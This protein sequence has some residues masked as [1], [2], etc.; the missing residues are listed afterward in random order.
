MCI[1]MYMSSNSKDKYKDGNTSLHHYAYSGNN[2]LLKKAL[3]ADEQESVT[4]FK[5]LKTHI[6]INAKNIFGFTPL[7]YAAYT[8]QVECVETLIEYGAKID[9][10]DNNGYT[11][12][13]LMNLHGKI[14]IQTKFEISKLLLDA[15]AN[16]SAVGKNRA[17]VF[18]RTGIKLI[19]KSSSNTTPKSNETDKSIKQFVEF[20]KTIR[21]N[22]PA[23]PTIAEEE[24]EYKIKSPSPRLSLSDIEHTIRKTPYRINHK[25][26]G[27][28]ALHYAVE[29]M[30]LANVKELIQH[31][32]DVNLKDDKNQ[33]PK[34]Y[35]KDLYKLHKDE[36]SVIKIVEIQMLLEDAT[37]PSSS[38]TRKRSLSIFVG[39]KKMRRTRNKKRR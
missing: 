17:R 6:H 1:T 24:E 15:G 38:K 39:G 28:T 14:S 3:S 22:K 20:L 37:P 8:G 29:A 18:S 33:I 30:D 32:A 36:D 21:K 12:F 31:G 11:P 26:N 5:L 34:D 13:L 25:F 10:R 16:I 19:Q 9:E 35:I 7:H 4:K 27:K 23:M 2:F